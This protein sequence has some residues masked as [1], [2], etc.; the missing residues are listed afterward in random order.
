MPGVLY[1]AVING[2]WSGQTPGGT[3]VD[4]TNVGRRRAGVSCHHATNIWGHSSYI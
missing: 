2:G 3:R 4:E 1:I